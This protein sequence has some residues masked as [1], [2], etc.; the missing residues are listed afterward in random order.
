LAGTG[1][2]GEFVDLRAE[3]DLL[4]TLSNCP[5]PCDPRA[6]YGDAAVEVMV[7]EAPPP[8]ADDACRTASEEAIRGYENTDAYTQ[9]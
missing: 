4:V 5:H 6:T 9:S 1:A 3:L 7:W 8:A 2:P